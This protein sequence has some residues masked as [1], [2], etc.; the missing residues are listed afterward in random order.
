MQKFLFT[1]GTDG[2]K[3]AQTLDEL[4][5]L[6]KTSTSPEK[7]RIWIIPG[8]QWI[9]Y[10]EFRKQFTLPAHQATS[11]TYA[12]A[13][14]PRITD[15]TPWLKKFLFFSIAGVAIYLLYNFTRVKWEK[16]AAVNYRASRPSNV[17]ALDV[18]SIMLELEYLRGQ[19]LDRTTRTNLRIRNTWP[20]RILLSVQSDRDTSSV[21]TRFYNISL[22]IDNTT[23]YQID[24][25]VVQL[26]EWTSGSISK[27]D[28]F[29]LNYIG[30]Q[31]P[32][33][34]TIPNKYK[35]DSLSV[36]FQSIKSKSFNFCYSAIKQS[37]YGSTSDRW[38]CRD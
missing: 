13:K 15:P 3:E 12:S 35:G 5:G 31:S 19:K 33:I 7:I 8:Q 26:E 9:S 21:G 11:T 4:N 2:V 38:F 23:G 32:I 17:P 36:S 25:T 20:D 18:D 29:H 22:T 14:R 28:T 37:N 27:R 6:I 34:R 24:Q 16:V 10:P 1:D 30:Y